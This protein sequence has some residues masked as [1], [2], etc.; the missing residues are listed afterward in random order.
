MHSLVA[1]LWLAMLAL[2]SGV[3]LCARV[4]GSSQVRVASEG[5]LPSISMPAGVLTIL[6]KLRKSRNQQDPPHAPIK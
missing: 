5:T 3:R 4:E 2:P 6:A 1:R